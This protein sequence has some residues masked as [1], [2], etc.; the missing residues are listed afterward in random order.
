MMTVSNGRIAMDDSRMI[1]MC[2][3]VQFLS[4]LIIMDKI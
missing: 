2:F 4:L 1:M 3:S